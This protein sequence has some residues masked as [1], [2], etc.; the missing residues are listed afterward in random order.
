MAKAD[1]GGGVDDKAD[2]TVDGNAD[3]DGNAF[4]ALTAAGKKITAANRAL[5]TPG[6]QAVSAFC[7]FP[8]VLWAVLWAVLLAAFL[9]AFL[10]FPTV[11]KFARH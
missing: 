5:K 6:S 11:R 4:C 7:G 2:G 10:M 3:G 9:A 1:A 8:A